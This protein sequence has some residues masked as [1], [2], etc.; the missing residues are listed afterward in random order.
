M[1]LI[2]GKRRYRFAVHAAL[3]QGGEVTRFPR[4]VPT[5]TDGVVTL[6][7]HRPEDAQGALE[8]S[9]DPVSRQ[10]TT[11]PLDY[12]LDHA[13]RFVGQAM[14]AGWEQDAEWGFALS[15]VDDTGNERYAGSV[16]L[17]NEGEGRAEIA[18]G[19][20]PWVRGRGLVERALRLLL[21][22]GFEHKDLN[23]VIWWANVGNWSSRKVA[24]RLG[25]SCHGPLPQWLP[26]R[27]QLKDAWVGV[28]RASDPQEPSHA[29]YDV[30]RIVG[31]GVVLREHRAGDVNRI[32]EACGDQRT[33]YW[34]GRLPTPYTEAD[35]VT[36]LE[37]RVERCATGSGVSW[38]V[39]DPSSDDLLANI[40]VFD[41]KPGREAE[42]GYWTHPAARGR[43]VMT[44]ACRLVVR[45]CFVPVGDGGLGL[46]K[47][48]LIAA[49]PNTAS[50]H[51]AER[52]RFVET[53]RER[54]AEPLGDGS[55]VEAIRYDLLAEELE[56]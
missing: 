18:Y 11:I 29:W 31:Q 13:K 46:Q 40:S 24:W 35:A 33:Q 32:V 49:A 56:V 39:A 55:L 3:G 17:R 2:H 37:Q 21:R 23:T 16:S 19:S 41:I 36:F 50:R 1:T 26:Q 42:V 5:L 27:G 9:L 6:R 28:L 15:A 22:W 12:T 10:W 38:A 53:G 45:H 30:P 51:V 43:G 47:V 54:R 44:E 52:C 25:F 20:H 4:D 14:P 34:L 48:N 7:P 8:Q